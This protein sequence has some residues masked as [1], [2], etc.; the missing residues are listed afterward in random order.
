MTGVRRPPARPRPAPPRREQIF[1]RHLALLTRSP[2]AAPVA[3]ARARA[4]TAT[5]VFLYIIFYGCLLAVFSGLLVGA[6]ESDVDYEIHYVFFVFMWLGFAAVG[7]LI[8]SGRHFRMEKIREERSQGSLTPRTPYACAARTRLP[9]L[10][11]ATRAQEG[12][13]RPRL[14]PR[15]TAGALTPAV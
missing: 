12:L 7:Y 13:T 1:R 6:R 10:Q 4:P 15:R 2:R 8:H 14:P 9:A 11:P 5:I 3:R